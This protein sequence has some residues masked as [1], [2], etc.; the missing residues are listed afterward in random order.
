MPNR[1]QIFA[2]D[3]PVHI[4]LRSD[5]SRPCFYA[6]EDYR[7]FLKSLQDYVIETSCSLHAYV[8]M[9]NHIHMLLTPAHKKSVVNLIR[10]LGEFHTQYINR[11]YR[12]NESLLGNRFSCYLIHEENLFLR[13]QRYIELNPV[14]GGIVNYPG[15]YP[16]SSYRANAH[17]INSSPLTPH[18][19]Y[20]L[21]G[22]SK[23][24]RMKIYRGMFTNLYDNEGVF[25]LDWT[26][27]GSHFSDA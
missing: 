17:G 27:N 24:Q 25:S 3:I 11:T 13:C 14:R 18:P 4:I 1:S 6:A 10:Q 8:L 15:E 22:N 12:K 20:L 7:Y 2:P 5:N 16:W 26:E 19:L 23:A 9:S 21:L